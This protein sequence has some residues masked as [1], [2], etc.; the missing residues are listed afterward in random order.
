MLPKTEIEKSICEY[1][2]QIL[3]IECN[4]IE[5]NIFALGMDSLNV[6]DLCNRT[7]K[8]YNIN[9][10]VKDIFDLQTIANISNKIESMIGQTNTNVIQIIPKA[11]DKKMY[12]ATTA[13]TRI[14]F[15]SQ[16]KN[17]SIVYNMPYAMILEGQFNIY[18]F[19]TA[20]NEIIK[21]QVSLQISF[22][23]CDG[24]LYQK[25]NNIS[26]F[27]IEVEKAKENE[28]EKKYR[29]FV[30]SFDFSK[31]PLMRIK[32]LQVSKTKHVLLFDMHHII[33]DGMSLH[34]LADEI[35]QI[36]EGQEVEVSQLSFLDYSQYENQMI[37]EDRFNK[38]KEYW[39]NEFSNMPEPLNMPYDYKKDGVDMYIG[40]K[41][42]YSLQGEVYEK[43]QLFAQDNDVTPNIVLLSIYY[44]LLSRYSQNADVVIGMPI[45]NRDNVNLQNS[46]GMY[47]NELPVRMFVDEEYI[48]VEFLKAVKDKLI[49]V[50][51]NSNYPNGQILQL[52]KKNNINVKNTLF[53]TMFV[54]QNKGMPTLNLSNIRTM[55]YIL[56]N[57]IS[58]YNFSMEILDQN[59]RYDINIEYATELFENAT[60][61]N[62][63]NHYINILN[64]VLTNEKIKIEKIQ[65]LGE[66]EKNRLIHQV[67]NTKHNFNPNE[68]IHKM[69]SDR[70]NV[71]K[72]D[73][74]LVFENEKLTYTELEQKTNSLAKVLKD[75]GAG[76]NDVIA[77]MVP[78]S[79]EMLVGIIGVLKA[80]AS[81][82]PVD[83]SYPKERIEYMLENS[84][85]KFVLVADDS[86]VDNDKYINISLK[87]NDIYE[88]KNVKIENINS[89]EDVAYL[90]Y[91][92]GSTG[93]P[94]GVMVKHKGITNLVHYANDNIEF[95][96]DNAK[97]RIVSVTTMSFD[98]FV[99]ET[100]IAL[101]KGLTVVIA[102]EDEQRIPSKLN[103]L[104]EKN[105]VDIIQTTP[106]R[107][108]MLIDYKEDMPSLKKLKYVV[109]AGEQYKQ[110]LFEDLKKI[111]P[112][113][114]SYNGYGPSETTIFSTLTLVNKQEKI[115]IGKP[116]YNT[117]MYVLDSK[118]RIVPTNHIGELYIGGDG[119]SKGYINND[120]LTKERFVQNPYMP[121]ETIY[122][123]G[124]LVRVLENG[125][126]E[127]LGRT[128]SQVKIR[129]L[130][131]EL[132]EIEKVILA[133]KM[134]DKVV[135][136]DKIDNEN[137]QYL[138]AYFT[139]SEKIDIQD[140][141]KNISKVLPAYMVPT[142][143]KQIEEFK[144]TPN[145]KIDK[146]E[147]RKC[148]DKIEDRVDVKED[149]KTDMQKRLLKLYKEI[150]GRN[151]IGITDNFF[152]MGG[153]SILAMRLQITLLKENIEV[154][155]GDIFNFP[156][157]ELL[158]QKIC[159]DRK[160][161]KKEEKI[162]MPINKYDSI[163]NYVTLEE[164]IKK[165]KVK[166]AILTGATGYVGMH[167]LASLLDNKVGTVYC[168]VRPKENKSGFDRLK[169]KLHFYFSTKY[170]KYINKKIIV[171][172][173]DVTKGNL[174]FTKEMYKKVSKTNVV[175]INAL[176]N[177]SHYGEES[178]F[179]SANVESVR[180]IAKFCME[181]NK[182]LFHISTIS[183]S[184]NALADQTYMSND[185]QGEVKFKESN[186]YIK[187]P[188]NNIYIKTKF[189]AERI[190]L[191]NIM[192]GL[193]GYILRVGNVMGRYI[194]GHF[195]Q[196]VKEN[197]YVNRLKAIYNLGAIPEYIKGGYLEFTPVDCLANS[198][199][200][201]VFNNND[202]NR[203]FHLF[204]N[205]HIPIT[206]FINIC[207]KLYKKIDI[208]SEE[209]FN[210]KLY[211]MLKSDNYSISFILND[212]NKDKKLQYESNIKIDAEF[213]NRYL[214]KI[215]FEWPEIEEEYIKKFF[216]YLFSIDFFRKE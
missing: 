11:N 4:N 133:T 121:K 131:I 12:K 174:F 23:M 129:G 195:Q 9:I 193:D 130:R 212:L 144:Y 114:I 171:I 30:K 20:I 50:F 2:S 177:V 150:L 98:I 41:I 42:Q 197:A 124:D 135:V 87:V 25:V 24:V 22:E 16:M 122:Q 31:A 94:K 63:L 53:D 142:H 74:A 97:R 18:N 140:L 162:S 68:T 107:M 170:D 58:K 21:R 125:E 100:L 184:G 67:N 14:Y 103:A 5:E 216:D 60:M 147:L 79:L 7:I 45:A 153:D 48:F 80:G 194:D 134:V 179:Y 71:A 52:L 111:N 28:I 32:I 3:N 149:A 205:K 57:N 62:F 120:E 76:A 165:N 127:C 6:I 172:E 152:D 69:I 167:I 117:K 91:T 34:I 49:N 188:L 47:A 164:K 180:N 104:I 154:T 8:Q 82:M 132:E 38:E 160:N 61:I 51:D 96:K 178:E 148:I 207:E 33:S 89:G 105:S 10:T 161:E 73:I 196:N 141:R 72:N 112:N 213:T 43:I 214:R 108:Q 19:K 137:R 190:M 139:A 29:E 209:K 39:L 204:N 199:T 203:V 136:V 113:V 163:L 17:D 110:K 126:F 56:D 95:L 175:F 46:I 102:N 83:I 146:I 189:M 101:Q 64:E 169:E 151:D 143:I 183:V 166:G 59:D 138:S 210:K 198:I 187:Q 159:T 200:K 85:A 77:I 145:G 27:D 211:E 13:Q 118:R 55:P 90:I 106:S 115:N 158:E 173:T 181:C 156:T 37:E 92:S 192:Q 215:G 36:Y 75:K 155:Y 15:A 208:L 35:S 26:E 44:I 168:L 84:N 186:L 78:R 81:Y 109:L 182:K 201:I 93:K 40:K 123:T 66:E 65:M 119:L 88:N 99:F 202:K 206:A 191:D 128:D 157:V 116:I 185:I 176:A 86:I 70:A 54:F 1:I